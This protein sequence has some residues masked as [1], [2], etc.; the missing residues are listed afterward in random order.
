LAYCTGNLGA[1]HLLQGSQQRP[2][3]HDPALLEP[4]DAAEEQVATGQS[5]FQVKTNFFHF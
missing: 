4:A 2:A 3:R 1:R 5:G